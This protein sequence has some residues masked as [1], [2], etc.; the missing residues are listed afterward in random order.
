MAQWHLYMQDRKWLRLF[1]SPC[2][3][4]NQTCGIFC[5]YNFICWDKWDIAW[6]FK[7]SIGNLCYYCAVIIFDKSNTNPI[8]ILLINCPPNDRRGRARNIT[9]SR[10]PLPEDVPAL[11]SSWA[12]SFV[13]LLTS[14]CSPS[15]L[16]SG[17]WSS[18]VPLS[19]YQLC[20]TV[21]LSN[22]NWVN[23]SELW[24][25]QIDI[26]YPWRNLPLQ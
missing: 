15:R 11:S 20:T 5:R 13:T 24:T 17:G 18:C 16:L 1:K 25:N 19:L 9:F 23:K 6:A 21:K 7:L 3:N 2:N 8:N 22:G 4:T 12:L 10:H 14:T 26:K